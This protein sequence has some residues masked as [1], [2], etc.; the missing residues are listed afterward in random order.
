MFQ[1][2]EGALQGSA[3]RSSCCQK[4]KPHQGVP[5]RSCPLGCEMGSLEWELQ[6]LGGL[7]EHG[8]VPAGK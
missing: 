2:A 8:A 6:D 4:T 7:Q 1:R 3:E 5:G